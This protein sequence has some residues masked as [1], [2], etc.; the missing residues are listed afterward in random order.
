MQDLSF[1]PRDPLFDFNGIQFGV[2]IFTFENVYGLDP[3]RCT[4]AAEAEALI[5]SCR[6]LTW[7]GGQVRCEGEVLI[8]AVAQ[9]KRTC[10]TVEAH[11]PKTIRSVKLVVANLPESVIV[12]LR[13]TGERRI[14]PEGLILRYPGGW[15]DLYT[16]QVILRGLDGA[17][18]NI[19]SLDTRVRA[20]TVALG[21]RQGRLAVEL[22]HEAL[23]IEGADIIRVPAWEIGPCETLEGA[24]AE[25]S[26]HTAAAYNLVPWE[27]RP[28]VP[29]WARQIA[30]VAAIHCQ[31]FTGY[32]FNDY[33]RVLETICWLSDRIEPHRLLV[34]LPGWEGR[35]Y[36][37]YGEYRPDPRMGGDEGFAHLAR[38]ARRLGVHL[39]PMFGINHVNRAMDNYEQW[40]APAAAMSAGGNPTAGSV[41]WDGSRHFDHAWGSLLNPG[42]PTWQQRLVG[43]ITRLIDRFGFDGVFLDISAGWWNDPKHAVYDGTVELIARLRAGR[44]ELLVAGEGWYDALGAATPLMQSGHT[45]GVLHWHDQPYAP[46]FDA[47]NRGFAH[48][49]LG[50]PSRGST[51]AH[52]LGYNPIRRAPLRK[53][54]IPTVTI[55]E[56]TLRLAPDAVEQIIEDARLYVEQYL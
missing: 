8:R 29:S 42:S 18:T 43:Q 49:C 45:D 30:L 1:D 41:D 39:M 32:V 50:D 10:V 7:A 26:A 54:I 51:G 14:G 19:R 40:G 3:A 47:H 4:V 37:Q 52:E 35:Y 12:N 48:L 31:H 17:L 24:L 6:G 44:P 5:V 28:D 21:Y 15:R 20:K 56:D 2:Q 25:Q 13:E 46:A 23:A 38:E 36:W 55:V 11:L 9:G 34:Y 53:G 22:I 27:Q 33:A 16:P